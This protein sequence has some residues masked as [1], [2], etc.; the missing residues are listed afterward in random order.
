MCHIRH[1]KSA[2]LDYPCPQ[3]ISIRADIAAHVFGAKFVSHI[4][5]TTYTFGMSFPGH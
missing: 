3:F 5:I 4:E 2:K 1:I